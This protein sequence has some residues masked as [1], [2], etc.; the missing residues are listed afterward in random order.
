M[1]FN[2]LHTAGCINLSEIETTGK[3]S[4]IEAH[5]KFE[6]NGSVGLHSADSS[7]GFEKD[8]QVLSAGPAIDVIQQLKHR[9]EHGHN[10]RSGLK[11]VAGTRALRC[12]RGLAILGAEDQMP[13][14]VQSLPIFCGQHGFFIAA[15]QHGAKENPAGP[16]DTVQFFEPR[17]LLRQ[18]YVG[19]D[20]RRDDEIHGSRF[21][22]RQG[23]PEIVVVKRDSRQV[24]AAPF[25]TIAVDV[26]T[27]KADASDAAQVSQKPPRTA[28]EFEDASHRSN[29]E[30]H[31][32]QRMDKLAHLFQAGAEVEVRIQPLFDL[33]FRHS[34]SG[35]KEMFRGGWSWVRSPETP[36]KPSAH[37]VVEPAL[38][39]L[40][41]A[42]LARYTTYD[43]IGQSVQHR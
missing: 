1:A 4:F 38:R 33:G 23:R 20:R 36:G 21:Q 43:R 18:R 3:S 7:P 8:E 34:R 14:L 10:L 22:E 35:P 17:S 16:H 25:Y 37:F 29:I 28:T 40:A 19:E 41:T 30:G 15:S 42:A 5:S 27:D 32:I 9:A 12:Q 39:H 11:N 31:R 6:K 26:G 13:I 24:L 2:W